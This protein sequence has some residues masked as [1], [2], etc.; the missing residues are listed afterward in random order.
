MSPVKTWLLTW[1]LTWAFII[2][3]VVAYK[4]GQESCNG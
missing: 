1:V 4:L 2:M 3:V